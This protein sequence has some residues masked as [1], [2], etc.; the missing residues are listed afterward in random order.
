[1][2]DILKI[3]IVIIIILFVLLSWFFPIILGFVT[4]NFWYI[5]LY[6]V[7]WIPSVLI[8][9]VCGTIINEL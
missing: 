5:L 4:G 1:M 7:W 2:K 8:T 6:A 3:I 9:M